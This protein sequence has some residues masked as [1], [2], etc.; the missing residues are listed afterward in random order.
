M[1][2]S[3]K[4]VLVR[5]IEVLHQWGR[6]LFQQFKYV[7]CIFGWCYVVFQKD[8][9]G[10]LWDIYW[11]LFFCFVLRLNFL[12]VAIEEADLRIFHHAKYAIETESFLF[13]ADKDVSK[14]G[15]RLSRLKQLSNGNLS[16]F[17]KH[18]QVNDIDNHANKSPHISWMPPTSLK[19][20]VN[21]LRALH[22]T[23]YSCILWYQACPFLIIMGVNNAMISCSHLG[24]PL[25]RCFQKT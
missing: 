3:G 2:E 25:Q 22:K 20:K 21:C 12:S 4:S 18:P 14:F 11:L 24:L 15:T 10:N 5:E 17:G 8:W 6:T 19:I 16:D 13:S 9:R 23:C 7:Q 1:I